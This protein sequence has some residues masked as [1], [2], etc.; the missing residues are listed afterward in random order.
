MGPSMA[1]EWTTRV[2][3]HHF[4]LIQAGFRFSC[5]GSTPRS[6]MLL[7]PLQMNLDG[8]DQ[9]CFLILRCRIVVAENAQITAEDRDER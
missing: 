6:A 5:E 7:H 2:L 1:A 4:P 3:T 9:R 8:V